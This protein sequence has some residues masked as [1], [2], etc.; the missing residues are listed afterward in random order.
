MPILKNTTHKCKN[1]LTA[2]RQARIQLIRLQTLLLFTDMQTTLFV[3][4]CA[5]RKIIGNLIGLLSSK[6]DQIQSI[7][8][9][10][11]LKVYHWILVFFCHCCI[12]YQ[13]AWASSGKK[14]FHIN[15]W[16]QI[17]VQW[18]AWWNGNGYWIPTKAQDQVQTS[19][20]KP[21]SPSPDCANHEENLMCLNCKLAFLHTDH[22]FL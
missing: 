12:E 7:K 13:E 22:I 16:Y 17:R 14:T 4:S 11:S 21:Q 15:K 2:K 19:P 5:N 20:L 9:M 6:L 3:N 18:K 10:S 8:F 1:T